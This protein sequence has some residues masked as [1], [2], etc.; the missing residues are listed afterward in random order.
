[1]LTGRQQATFDTQ[2][3]HRVNEAE[4]VHAHADGTDN[5]GLIDIDFVG[6]DG[7]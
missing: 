5:A 7:E 3:F 4:A 1:M 6:R 2:F